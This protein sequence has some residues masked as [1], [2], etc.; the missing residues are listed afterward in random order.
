MPPDAKAAAKERYRKRLV[1]LTSPAESDSPRK[2]SQSSF[3]SKR[4]KRNKER[5]DYS[6]G[7]QRAAHEGVHVVETESPD[8]K[9]EMESKRPATPHPYPE[10]CDSDSGPELDPLFTHLDL[11]EHRAH[12]PEPWE[13]DQ[14]RRAETHDYLF[15]QF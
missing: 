13:E 8:E 2:A 14:G 9:V 10:A 3:S 12:T 7:A 15:R 4:S 5:R 1:E 11:L 6:W